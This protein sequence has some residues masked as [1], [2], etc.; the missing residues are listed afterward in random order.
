MMMMATRPD[1]KRQLP[2]APS[3]GPEPGPRAW[4]CPHAPMPVLLSRA[5][6]RLLRAQQL[7]RQFGGLEG[8]S[9]R[10]C[11]T[12]PLPPRGRASG[13]QEVFLLR[14][15][16][17]RRGN[18]P[19]WHATPSGPSV[20][21]FVAI[22]YGNLA[23]LALAAVQKIAHIEPMLLGKGDHLRAHCSAL[24]VLLVDL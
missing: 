7:P 4:A 2:H 23:T 6:V 12:S 18:E 14:L 8:R 10:V 16:S 20:S 1:A 13:D 11:L 9:C 15:S 21:G 3:L 24:G 17:F 19:A 5:S 22:L